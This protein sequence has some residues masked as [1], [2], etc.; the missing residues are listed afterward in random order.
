M[1]EITISLTT[2]GRA[3]RVLGLPQ[4]VLPSKDHPVTITFPSGAVVCMADHRLVWPMHQRSPEQVAGYSMLA[5]RVLESPQHAI[6]TSK[7][8]V[9]EALTLKGRGV[10]AA[11]VPSEFESL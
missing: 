3:L 1:A 2:D 10:A 11:S 5:A 8:E 9:A 4:N 6:R 7:F